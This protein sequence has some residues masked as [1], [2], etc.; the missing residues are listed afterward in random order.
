MVAFSRSLVLPALLLMGLD[1]FAPDW[2]LLLALPMAE[3]LTFGLALA[4]FV[5]FQ[6]QRLLTAPTA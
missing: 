3:W 1:R 4:L 5:R 6:P 2:P